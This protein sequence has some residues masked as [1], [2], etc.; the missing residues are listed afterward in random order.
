MNKRG[1]TVT[2]IIVLILS[3]ALLLIIILGPHNILK[4]VASGAE[5]LIEKTSFGIINGAE[6]PALESDKSIE[7]TFEN[8]LSILRTEENGPCIFNYNP[9][10]DEISNFRIKLTETEQGIYVELE[11]K[12]KQVVRYNTVSGKLPCVVGEGDAAKNFYKNYLDGT[13]CKDNCLRDYSKANLEF[14]DI[15]TI[16]INGNER[17]LD[18][19]NLVFK[20]SDGNVCF[21]PT[22]TING[23]I[24]C[25]AAEEG[26]DDDCIYDIQ[27]NNNI[28]KC[29]GIEQKCSYPGVCVHTSECQTN[30]EI[31]QNLKCEGDNVCCIPKN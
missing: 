15:G 19:R 31:N 12:N 1:M 11:N 9:F 5:Y 13:I 27:N 21:F 29:Q 25:D 28:P 26:L 30:Y 22:K 4:M 7:E 23:W 18:D 17:S 16:Y 8:I 3:A 6:K 14:N 20:T 10:S 24:G 2:A